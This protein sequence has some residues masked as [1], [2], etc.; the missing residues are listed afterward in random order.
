VRI[1]NGRIDT[2]VETKDAVYFFEFKLKKTAEEAI[3]QID[4]KDYLLPWKGKGKKLYK[5]G[6]AIDHEKRNIGEW[7]AELL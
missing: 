5:I 6:V 3:A 7:K 4:A 2:L 1:S